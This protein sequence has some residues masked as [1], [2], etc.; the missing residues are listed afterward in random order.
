MGFRE[1]VFF[2]E[3]DGFLAEDPGSAPGRL[4]P[5]PVGDRAVSKRSFLRLAL[6][7][8]AGAA[9]VALAPAAISG[10]TAAASGD[11]IAIDQVN[12]GSGNTELD[13]SA[14]SGAVFE[15]LTSAPSGS[16]VGLLGQSSSPD[17][18]G[19]KGLNTSGSGDAVGVMGHS[20]SPA[21]AGVLGLGF[22]AVAGTSTSPSSGA[23]GLRGTATAGT[24]PT[25][26]VDGLVLSTEGTGV[27]GRCT[28]LGGVGVHAVHDFPDGRGLRVEGRSQ[29]STVIDGT[30]PAG[31]DTISVSDSR[32][33]S[34]S[35]VVVVLA[36]DP[37][38]LAIGKRTIR[39]GLSWVSVAAG[40]FTV[41]LMMTAPS[42]VPFRA[43]IVEKA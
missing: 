43:F 41:R 32:V 7:G 19:V 18:I 16:T 24:G 38:G 35:E 33:T 36:G 8:G 42:A 6:L 31:S 27:R 13:S 11:P 26:G 22:L 20:Q 28:A 3:L 39:N 2:D 4:R 23:T 5:A 37:G 12:Q 25:F 30:I 40:T 29:F 1:R 21:G 15:G 14:S 9:A 34:G 17:G 10:R